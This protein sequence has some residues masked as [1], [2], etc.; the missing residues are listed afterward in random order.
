MTPKKWVNYDLVV[1]VVVGVVVVGVVGLLAQNSDGSL[2]PLSQSAPTAAAAIIAES[3]REKTR[4]E[5]HPMSMTGKF[6]P[7]S[8]GNC[9]K[10]CLTTNNKNQHKRLK[11][12]TMS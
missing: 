5:R 2:L 12:K 11:I 10:N 8:G 9:H 4:E 6:Y 1:V 7:K 3:K